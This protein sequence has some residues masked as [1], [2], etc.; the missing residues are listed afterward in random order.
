LNNQVLAGEDERLLIKGRSYKVTRAEEYEEPLPDGRTRVTQLE[1][2][3][4]VT[5]ITTVDTSG[6]VLIDNSN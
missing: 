6:Q 5:D 3:S 2:E 1:T 4:V